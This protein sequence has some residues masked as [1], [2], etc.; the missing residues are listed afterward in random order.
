LKARIALGQDAANGTEDKERFSS[1]AAQY[2]DYFEG[3]NASF[4][5]PLDL[6]EGTPFQQQVWRIV[7]AIPRGQTKTYQGVAIAIGKPGA[8]RAVGQAMGRN[9]VPIIIPCHRVVGSSGRP[10]GFGGGL[11]MKLYLLELEKGQSSVP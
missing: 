5:F 7:Q 9:P 8:A 6:S 11:A 3:R 10:G 1:L 4:E 2:Q